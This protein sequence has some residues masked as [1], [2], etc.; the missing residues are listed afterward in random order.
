MG[1]WSDPQQ[2]REGP[3]RVG[4]RGGGGSGR[5]MRVKGEGCPGGEEDGE[6]EGQVLRVHERSGRSGMKTGSEFWQV[7][8][9]SSSRY[10]ENVQR[11]RTMGSAR[12]G[13]GGDF[14]LSFTARGSGGRRR[15]P[16]PAP[17]LASQGS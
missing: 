3:R 2:L 15:K 4:Q 1:T 8:R 17:T 10:K 7:L 5:A 11:P 14:T 16:P 12:G 13:A 6:G 9:S